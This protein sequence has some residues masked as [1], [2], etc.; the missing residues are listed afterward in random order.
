MALNNHTVV[1][2]NIEGTDQLHTQEKMKTKCRE[3]PPRSRIGQ[4]ILVFKIL[5]D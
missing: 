2:I 4:N 1:E 3:P 5:L